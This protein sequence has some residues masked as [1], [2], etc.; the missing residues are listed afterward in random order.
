MS[1]VVRRGPGAIG[2]EGHSHRAGYL[3]PEEGEARGALSDRCRRSSEATLVCFGDREVP[4]PKFEKSPPE[5]VARFDEV[6]AR[7]PA[8]EHRTMFGYPAL[9]VGGNMACG[10]FA[11]GWVLRLGEADAAEALALPGAAP[12]APMP[13]RTAKGWV[14]LPKAIVADDEALDGWVARSEAHAASMP[15]K[16]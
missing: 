5:L 4:V 12:F 16:R 3:N 10:L 9:F 13:G 7:H 15:P 11:D 8:A 6:A 1:I 2:H 14:L